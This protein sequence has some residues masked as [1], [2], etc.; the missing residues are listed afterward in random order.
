MA[1][2]IHT[3]FTTEQ[4]KELLEKYIKDEVERKYLQEIIKQEYDWS[5]QCQEIVEGYLKV[6]YL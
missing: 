1:N 4:V 3:K 5:R 6:E 2:Q